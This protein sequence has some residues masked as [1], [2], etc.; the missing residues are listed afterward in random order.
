MVNETGFQGKK[1]ETKNMMHNQFLKEGS[2]FSE[3][4]E[5]KKAGE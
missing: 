4:S 1:E 5:I 2:N 3:I